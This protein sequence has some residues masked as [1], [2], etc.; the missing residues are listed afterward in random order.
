MVLLPIIVG[1]DTFIEFQVLLSKSW[2]NQLGLQ[3]TLTASQQRGKTFPTSDL[4]MTLNNLI[5]R[6]WGMRRTPS[7]P[8]LPGQLC[9]G[10][11]TPNRVLSMGQIEL[12]CIITLNRIVQN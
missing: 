7:L 3:N 4:D 9:L 8:S 2:P 1:L 12:I 5:V 11:V 10:V 6:L